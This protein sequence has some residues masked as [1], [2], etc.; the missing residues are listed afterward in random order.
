MPADAS[1]TAVVK[2]NID[3][4]ADSASWYDIWEA[5][6]AI[7]YMCG[8]SEPQRGGKATKIGEWIL[9]EQELQTSERSK[10]TAGTLGNIYIEL[11]DQALGL[12]QSKPSIGRP[13]LP[14]NSTSDNLDE[15]NS[16]AQTEVPTAPYLTAVG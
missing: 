13:A 1:G 8:K 3:G 16:S 7:A 11:Y 9:R 2:I 4:R 5:L 10:C 14:D 15:Q 6:N 12:A